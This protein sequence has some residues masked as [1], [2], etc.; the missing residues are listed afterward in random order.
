MGDNWIDIKLFLEKMPNK[1]YQDII[2]A[3]LEVKRV[4]K[5]KDIYLGTLIS[6]RNDRF[7]VWFDTKQT[8]GGIFGFR[9]SPS[10]K[11]YI[12]LTDS[13]LKFCWI[14]LIQD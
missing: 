12:K 3:T 13:E 10:D 11:F 1:Y 9:I 8:N 4:Y 14:Y 7:G 6:W 2:D 5:S